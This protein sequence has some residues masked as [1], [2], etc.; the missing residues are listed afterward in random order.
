MNKS[1]R[2]PCMLALATLLAFSSATAQAAPIFTDGVTTT[3][4]EVSYKSEFQGDM[5]TLSIFTDAATGFQGTINSLKS[6]VFYSMKPTGPGIG[7]Q[8]F[9]LTDASMTGSSTQN[10]MA[11]GGSN[12]GGQMCFEELNDTLVAG[13]P[14][15]YKIKFDYI[16]PQADFNNFNV[17]AR[18]A[19]TRVGNKGQLIPFEQN[20]VAQ[21]NATEVPEP[22]SLAMLG[23]GLG[24]VCLTRRRKST[25]A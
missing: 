16:G 24:M 25:A 15:V 10:G 4:K 7:N 13:E 1:F 22:A 23:L 3:A 12:G 9:L 2:N 8:F 19:G 20:D 11:C 5:L 6:L 21:L 14:L 17:R 18:F